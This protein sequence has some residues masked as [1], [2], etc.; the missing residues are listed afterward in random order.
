MRFEYFCDEAYFGMYAIKEINDSNFLSTIHVKTEEEAKFIV[1]K[2]NLNI[3][4]E[5]KTKELCEKILQTHSDFE[6]IE[7][8][9][10]EFLGVNGNSVNCKCPYCY[11]KMKTKH[12]FFKNSMEEIEHKPNCV[13]LLSKNLLELL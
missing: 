9:N 4:L 12:S 8:W 5:E 13:Y 3:I 11:E 1:E 7:I 10:K 2:L 6:D